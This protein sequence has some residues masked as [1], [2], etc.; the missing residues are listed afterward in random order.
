MLTEAAT[1]IADRLASGPT[2]TLGLIRHQ[3][4]SALKFGFDDMLKVESQ[5]QNIAGATSD[6]RDSLKV[7]NEGLPPVF[8][9]K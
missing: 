6:V 2:V 5:N 3:V 9:G 1:K 8:T 4:N 7:F